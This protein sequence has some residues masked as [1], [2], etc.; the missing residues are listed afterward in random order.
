MI[1]TTVQVIKQSETISWTLNK[2]QEEQVLKLINN[3][4]YNNN[5][6]SYDKNLYSFSV[7]LKV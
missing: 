5:I 2:I 7:K 6:N 3:N 4:N 1:F